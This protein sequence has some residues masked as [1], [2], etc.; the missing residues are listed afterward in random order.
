MKPLGFYVAYT[1]G[2]G[3]LLGEI[4]N[5]WGST[6]EKMRN[7]E[8]LWFIY[9][10]AYELWCDSP[11]DEP[12]SE[13]VERAADRAKSELSNSDRIGLITALISQTTSV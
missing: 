2:D 1:P 4:E 11:L 8:K 3:G 9:R 13:D 7:D 6:F 5:A 10:L 12:P